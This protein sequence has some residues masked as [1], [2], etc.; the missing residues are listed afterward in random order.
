MDIRLKWFYRLGF[1]LL[2]FFV[3]LIF[4]KLK[5]IWLPIL[6]VAATVLGPFLIAAFISYLLHPVVE[7]LHHRGWNRGLSIAL[8]Y[9]LFFGAAGFGLYKGIPAIMAQGNELAK[10]LPD[11]AERY[12]EWMKSLDHHTSRWPFGIHERLERGIGM[13]EERIAGM[14]EKVIGYSMRVFDFILLAALIPFMA[15]YILKDF[16]H[17]KKLAWSAVPRK[18]R[19][20]G[21]GFLKDVDASLGG[22]IRGQLIVCSAIGIISSLLFWIFGLPYSLLLGLIVGIT[23]IIPYFGPI[24]GAVPAVVIAATMSLKMVIIVA[25]I[26]LVLQFLEG[27]ILSPLIVGKSLHM[28]PLF[29]MLALLAGG[30]VGGV[31]GMIVA[32]P[33]LAILKVTVVHALVHFRKREPAVDK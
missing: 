33:V 15:F 19:S 16:A 28:H 29:I 26:I 18:W 11:L 3:L 14:T 2:L 24:I 9:L 23:N 1:L 20:Q 4:W 21:E 25:I 5:P 8:I 31:L 27:N 17:L 32:I 30:E 12:K 22:Y 6:A 7:F 13:F 10:S